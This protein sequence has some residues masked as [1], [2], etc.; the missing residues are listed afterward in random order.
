MFFHSAPK[1]RAELPNK[2]GVIIPRDRKTIDPPLALNSGLLLFHRIALFVLPVQ[3]G[4]S[5]LGEIYVGRPRLIAKP[6][7]ECEMHHA[8][9]RIDLVATPAP[10]RSQP[11]IARLGHRRR[12]RG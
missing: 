7:D 12:Q 4:T 1:L 3:A 9:L 6:I 8:C 5:L 2:G 10:G 11:A